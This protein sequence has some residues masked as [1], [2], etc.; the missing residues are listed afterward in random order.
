RRRRARSCVAHGEEAAHQASRLD[1]LER[2]QLV[3][4]LLLHALATIGEATRL[5]QLIEPRRHPRDRLQLSAV[6]GRLSAPNQAR[7]IRQAS[8]IAIMTRW[9]MPPDIW[10]G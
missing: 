3:A 7:R 9:R 2:R 10:C 1:E 5:R 6:S 8:A 4:T